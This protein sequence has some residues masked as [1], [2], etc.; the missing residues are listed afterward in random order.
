MVTAQ[1]RHFSQYFSVFFF[2]KET[3]IIINSCFLLIKNTKKCWRMP[4]LR[5]DHLHPVGDLPPV[6]PTCKIAKSFLTRMK[7]F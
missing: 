3:R 6:Y 2:L 4:N 5:E 1:I 7:I